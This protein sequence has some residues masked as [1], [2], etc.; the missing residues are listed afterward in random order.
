[1]ERKRRGM[2]VFTSFGCD[3]GGVHVAAS[4]GRE[5]VLDIL[6]RLS[7]EGVDGS[8]DGVWEEG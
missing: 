1:M 4:A 5:A 6:C 3:T 7:L 8:I 2:A